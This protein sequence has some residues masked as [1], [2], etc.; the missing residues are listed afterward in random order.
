[1]GC[2]EGRCALPSPPPASSL[3]SKAFLKAKGPDLAS[4]SPTWLPWATACGLWSAVQP[5]PFYS[6]MTG[7]SELGIMETL[8]WEWGG[9][10]VLWKAA[11]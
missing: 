11:G 5:C 2:A 7:S 4:G 9:W 10:A 1:M 6:Q 8:P 3:E